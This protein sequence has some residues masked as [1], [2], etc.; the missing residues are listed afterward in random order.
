MPPKD[1]TPGTN[2][3][4][5]PAGITT[6]GTTP[7][8][9]EDW[10]ARFRG[11]S[12][13]HQELAQTFKDL[14]AESAASAAA[15]QLQLDTTQ[16]ALQAQ[17]EQSRA[18]VVSL[19]QQGEESAA[20]L[21]DMQTQMAVMEAGQAKLELLTVSHPDL[22]PFHQY[23]PHVSSSDG[24]LNNEE[25]MKA[26]IESFATLMASKTEGAV[27]QF[28]EGHVPTPPGAAGKDGQ[29]DANARAAWIEKNVGLKGTEQ[30]ESAEHLKIW[31]EQH[32]GA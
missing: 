31:R 29:L 23:I 25:A 24:T 5:T 26:A 9:A 32:P 7:P 12:R 13:T 10:E 8:V 30:G 17:L 6:P 28:R 18:Q 3:D 21:E 2:P 4:G 20:T 11:L 1:P 16:T 27:S 22:V 15:L 14:Q 19:T